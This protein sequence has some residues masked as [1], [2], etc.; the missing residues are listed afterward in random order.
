M[1]TE[2]ANCF[3]LNDLCLHHKPRP[4]LQFFSLKLAEN[5]VDGLVQLYGYI[6]VR[7]QMDPL[8]NYIANF[9]RDDPITVEQVH[10]DTYLQFS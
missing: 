3:F 10:T 2:P 5:P 1:F 4:M 9:T 7:D 6:A 8:L